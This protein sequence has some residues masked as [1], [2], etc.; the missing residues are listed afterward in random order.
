MEPSAGFRFKLQ[1]RRS[2][3]LVKSWFNAGLDFARKYIFRRTEH[4]RYV[5]RFVLGWT[6]II[7]VAGFALR[8]QL[9]QLK[10][11]Y[12]SLGPKSGGVV[13]EGAVGDIATINPLFPKNNATAT[14][15]KLIFNGL[16][17]YNGQGKIEADL[18]QDW[19]VDDSGKTYTFHLRKDV[20][21]H[22]GQPFVAKDVVYT[23][24]TAAN[25]T[26]TSPLTES[27]RGIAV[28]AADDHTVVFNLP[29]PYSP[30][31][32]SLT[33]GI[34]PAHVLERIEPSQLLKA[35]FNQHPVGTGPFQ[36]KDFSLARDELRLTANRHYFKGAP[37]TDGFILKTFADQ[38]SLTRAYSS[39]QVMLAGGLHSLE[40][41][42]LRVSAKSNVLELPIANQSFV[43]FNTEQ[44]SLQNTQVRKALAQATD[45]AEIVKKLGPGFNLAYGPLLRAQLGYNPAL[46]Q[47]D[48]DPAAAAANLDAA[49]W[50]LAGD[51]KRQQNGQTL[52]FELV[53]QN[54][55]VYPT[56]AAALQQQ[57]AKVGVQLQV[58]LVNLEQLQQD[59][60]R[61]RKYD[62]TL[63]GLAQGADPDVYAYWHSSQ[64]RNPGLN[65][66]LYKS[67]PAD[68]ALEAGRTRQSAQL[69]AA[70]YDAFLAAWR[71]DAPAVAIFEPDYFYATRPSILGINS[72]FLSTPADRFYNVE[73]WTV[74][75]KPVLKRN[76]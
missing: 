8:A 30:I 65:L 6:F 52:S 56:V 63:F 38:D 58:K 21:W 28:S 60:L 4:L 23:F 20:K 45:T 3:R 34:L 32:D 13:S 48:F 25:S 68:Q 26:T 22:D 35:D 51:H 17:Q 2:I 39:N 5:Q 61:P 72:K 41:D 66:S 46:R 44:P 43:F 14:A 64:S 50:K 73:K 9:H 70:K 31:L 75:T 74:K 7:V 12:L 69:R 54:S 1:R 16:V 11:L 76:H 55:D 18:A 15:N 36:F 71:D 62:M 27:W 47:L 53:A 19:Q 59:Y 33:T 24:T 57:W 10:P 67:T 40:V 49:G 42:Q 37:R 29:T